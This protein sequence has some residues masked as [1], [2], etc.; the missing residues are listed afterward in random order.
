MGGLI[1]MIKKLLVLV[2][3]LAVMFSLSGCDE[4]K[5]KPFEYDETQIVVDTMS[6]FISYS[7]SIFLIS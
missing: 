5:D 4:K 2:S 6:Y 3:M 1:E 7:E